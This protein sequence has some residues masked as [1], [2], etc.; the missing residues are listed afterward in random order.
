[1]KWGNLKKT[2]KGGLPNEDP[3]KQDRTMVEI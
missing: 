1:M 2:N 3:L